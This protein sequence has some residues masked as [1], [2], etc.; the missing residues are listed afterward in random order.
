MKQLFLILL[1]GIAIVSNSNAQD[2]PKKS[3]K[4]IIEYNNKGEALQKIAWI[5]SEKGF[6]FDEVNETI[7][8]MSTGILSDGKTEYRLNVVVDGEGNAMITGLY[9]VDVIDNKFSIIENRGMNGSPVKNAWNILEEV[10]TATGMPVRY[11]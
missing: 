8:I 2:A 7:G 4:A 6:Y 3:T 1:F 9:R 5:L 11:E 10:A